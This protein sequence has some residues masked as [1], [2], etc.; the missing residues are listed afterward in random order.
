MKKVL[1]LLIPLSLLVLSAPVGILASDQGKAV[2]GSLEIGGAGVG[3]SK[4][5]TRVNQY[6]VINDSNGVTPYYKAGLT[7]DGG[8]VDFDLDS[9]FMSRY[10]QNHDAS[11]DVKRALKSEFSFQQF[12]SWLHHDRMGYL[13]AAIPPPGSYTGNA[14]TPLPLTPDAVPAY[15]YTPLAGTTTPA[16]GGSSA[17]APPGYR[18]QQIGRATVYGEDLAPS[19]DFNIRHREWKNKTDFTLPQL[20]N[21]TLHFNFRQDERKG[22]EQSIGMSKCTSCH[23]TGGSKQID[24][25]TRDISAGLT[26]KFGLLTLDYTFLN[27]EFW[28]KGADP[29]MLYDPALAPGGA[30]AAAGPFDNRLLYDY[31][32]SVAAGGLRYNVTPDSRKNSH[33]VKTKLDLPRQTSIFASYV[34]AAVD[35]PKSDEPGTFTLDKSKLSST[36]DA[37]GG[38]ISTTL[39]DRLNLNVY[40]RAEKLEDDDVTISYT[41]LNNSQTNGLGTAVNPE[42][43]VLVRPSSVSRD[44]VTV[45]IDGVY[46]LARKT[47][48]RLGYE[49]Q[50]IE[51]QDSEFGDTK[52]STVKASL[53]TRPASTLSGRASYSYKHIDKPFQNPT[54]ALSLTTPNASNSILVGNGQTYGVQFYDLRVADLTN[55]PEDIH[56][57]RVSA[58]W[59]P[60]GRFS[61]TVDFK[62]KDERNELNYSTWQQRTYMPGVSFWYAPHERLTMTIAYNYQN[63]KTQSSMCQGLYDG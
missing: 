11:I 43:L 33:T 25:H 57:G 50:Q 61:A 9:R 59:S 18:V 63:Q 1:H 19:T 12:K 27:R 62:Y 16:Y 3:V 7:L 28:E 47:T 5:N 55:Q 24:E 58:T 38:R 4:D 42:S 32:K 14:A 53:N 41:T 8:G 26:G 23:I 2:S 52:T 39:F 17:T 34:N 29:R 13:D 22:I 56:D 45:G 54:A 37:Y 30:Y 60:S 46:R 6:S 20:P 36:Y 10:D 35:S 21:V 40:G 48:L 44:T 31:E 49:Y 15:W 51:R